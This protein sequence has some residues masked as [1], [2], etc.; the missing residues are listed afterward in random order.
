MAWKLAVADYFQNVEQFPEGSSTF[1]VGGRLRMNDFA[2][3]DLNSHLKDVDRQAAANV[4][5]YEKTTVGYDFSF[6]M[7]EENGYTAQVDLLQALTGGTTGVGLKGGAD[8]QRQTVRIFRIADTFAGLMT[9]DEKLDCGDDRPVD[10]AHPVRGNIGI[11]EMVKTFVQLNE[12]EKLAGAKEGDKVPVLSDTFNFQTTLSASATPAVTLSPVGHRYGL[13]DA[14]AGISG[15]RKDIHKVIVAMSLP[16]KKGQEVAIGAGAG[17]GL[18]GA[19]RTPPQS[20]GD[21]VNRALDE[22][23]NRSIV[24]QLAL[25][26]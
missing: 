17:A 16:V 25:P 8:F 2:F 26:R 9:L 5:S 24:N 22:Q 19:N 3:A 10:F 6:D 18:V 12:S 20:A 14:N 1:A 23:I 15:T 7:S 4:R 13:A 11:G 21:R